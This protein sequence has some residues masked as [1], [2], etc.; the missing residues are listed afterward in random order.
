MVDDCSD[1]K[2]NEILAKHPPAT[3]HCLR[4][5]LIVLEVDLFVTLDGNLN[6]V[7]LEQF[8]SIL[9]RLMDAIDAMG[10]ASCEG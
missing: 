4:V 1:E 7:E 5:M 8:R 6:P 3:A 2:L 10:V 9:D